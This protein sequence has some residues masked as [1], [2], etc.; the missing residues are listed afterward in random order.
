MV[1]SMKESTIIILSGFDILFK[2]SGNAKDCLVVC[3][4]I[5]N[6]D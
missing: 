5:S 6:G 3:D 4:I 2:V 1:D